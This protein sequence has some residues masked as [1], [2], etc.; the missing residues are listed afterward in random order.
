MKRVFV[1]RN[2]D[3]EHLFLG[4][5]LTGPGGMK[6]WEHDE[7]AAHQFP[8]EEWALNVISMILNGRGHAVEF[9]DTLPADPFERVLARAEVS[10]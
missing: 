6:T 7:R 5:R 10:A 1:I 4:G 2:A 9:I 8:S 3:N